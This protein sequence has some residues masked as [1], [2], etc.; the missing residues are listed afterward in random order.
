MKALIQSQGGESAIAKNEASI[1]QLS[2]LDCT[3]CLLLCS[4]S[5]DPYVTVTGEF[6]RKIWHDTNVW[7]SRKRERPYLPVI[8]TSSTVEIPLE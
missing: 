6:Y 2:H 7:V 5:S 8:G 4:D 3:T 1:G